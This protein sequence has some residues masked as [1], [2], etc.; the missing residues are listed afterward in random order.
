MKRLWKRRAVAETTFPM[1]LSLST[2]RC[3]NSYYLGWKGSHPFIE[4][5]KGAKPGG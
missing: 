5:D 4:D 1:G 2:M 3:S